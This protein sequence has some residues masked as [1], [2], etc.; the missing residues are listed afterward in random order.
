MTWDITGTLLNSDSIVV[1]ICAAQADCDDAFE[2]TVADEDRTYTYSGSQ[3]THGETYHLEVAV[4][5]EQGCSTLGI[6]SVVAD[7]QVDGDVAAT[8]LLWLPKTA[9]GL[10]R[11]KCPAIPA[12]WP[13][14]MFAGPPRI[15]PSVNAYALPRRCHGC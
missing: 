4:C 9:S 5:N 14:G 2:A 6:A 1:S 11:G 13:C 10:S 7:K 12:T 3:T 8:I 15:S